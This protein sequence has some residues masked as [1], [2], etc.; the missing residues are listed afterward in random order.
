M[1]RILS[2]LLVLLIVMTA[3]ATPAVACV[4][5]TPSMGMPHDCCEEAISAAPA[6]FCCVVSAPTSERSFVES[7]L[8]DAKE[9]AT[10]AYATLHSALSQAPGDRVDRR[11]GSPPLLHVRTTP[12]YL[13]Q[14]S[15][16][17]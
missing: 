4:G 1:R 16:L 11:G 14:L 6:G 10:H 12:L 5:T 13:Q 15:L 17:I 8:L 3:A 7:R 2:I 9:H